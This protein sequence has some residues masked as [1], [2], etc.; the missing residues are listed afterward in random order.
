MMVGCYTLD[1]YCDNESTEHEHSGTSYDEF[2]HQFTG[3]I[4]SEC[5][6]KARRAGWQLN[7]RTGKAIC[8]KCAG[9]AKGVNS[10]K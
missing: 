1:L 4:A 9:K 6:A 3:E 7:L 10:G 8:P 2:P 5:R